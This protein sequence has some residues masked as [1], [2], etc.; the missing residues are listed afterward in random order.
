[1][2]IDLNAMQSAL[3]PEFRAS[4]A[5]E[6][7]GERY[8]APLKWLGAM[9]RA[10]TLIRLKR[11]LYAFANGFD[12]LAAAGAM[13]GASYVSFESALEYY[14]L[15]PERVDTVMSVVDGRS[16]SFSTPVGLYVYYP[17][18]RE[19]FAQGMGMA[20]SDGR[21]F[22][23]ATR[24]KAVTDALSRARLRA[25]LLSPEQVLEFTVDGLRVDLEDLQ[26]LSLRTLRRLG[27]LYRGLGP[28]KLAAALQERGKTNE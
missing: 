27:T 20:L 8:K 12:R 22:L 11:G 23:L 18:G 9:E 4:E 16:A 15:I 25:A 21:S 1:M 5:C 24:E 2:R 6:Y 10:G 14:G 28:K 17:Q 26:A 3:P 19:L 13:H 7:L